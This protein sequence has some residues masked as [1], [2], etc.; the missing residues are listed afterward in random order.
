MNVKFF[1]WN[2]EKNNALKDERSISFEEI[3]VSIADGMLLDIIEHPNQ[4]EY[5]WQRIL[6]VA[7]NNYVYV[8]PCREEDE[9]TYLMTIYPSRKFTK[10]Y[11]IEGEV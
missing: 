5:P 7:V 6:V 1:D 2:E 3:L 11:R 8:V 10:T 4:S 9:I